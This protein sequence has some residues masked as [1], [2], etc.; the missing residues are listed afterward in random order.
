[1]K[2]MLLVLI[3]IISFLTL[4]NCNSIYRVYNNEDLESMAL[5]DFGFTTILFFKVVDSDTAVELTGDSYNNSGIIYGMKDGEY[6]MIFVP[7]LAS[8][9][10]FI[11]DY[12]PIYDVAEIYQLLQGLEDESGQLLF[13]DPSGDYGGL[14]VS[15]S[16]Y[17]SVRSEYPNL[18]F[19]S[20]IF[21]IVTTDEMIFN[22]GRVN[23]DYIVFNQDWNRLN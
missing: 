8:K 21:F 5:S 6:T 22:V 10:A 14:S 19:D 20:P 17:E 7:K 1:M 13:Q 12:D 16:P 4:S 23:G 18:N 15:V 9:E 2:K 11:V 3:S